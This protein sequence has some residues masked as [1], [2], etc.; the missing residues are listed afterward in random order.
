MH[1][2]GMSRCGL[3]IATL[4]LAVLFS[5]NAR[6]QSQDP[7]TFRAQLELAEKADDKASAVEIVRRWSAASPDDAKV[8]RRLTEVYLAAD[9][10]KRA[11]VA[12]EAA[13]KRPTLAATV[14]ELRGDV[15]A[16]N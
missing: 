9:D 1:K 8:L 7:A 14:V 13:A 16:A 4:L 11:L 15:A 3:K 6:A 5:P 12:L 10:P 2:P